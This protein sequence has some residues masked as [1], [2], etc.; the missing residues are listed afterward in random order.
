MIELTKW[1]GLQ[2]SSSTMICMSNWTEKKTIICEV[3]LKTRKRVLK[4]TFDNN[5][6]PTVLFQIDEDYLLVGTADGKLEMWNIEHEKIVLQHDAHENSQQGI[7]SIVELRDPSYCLRGERGDADPEIR[8]LVTSCFDRPEFKM[9][10]MNVHA[11]QGKPELSF[12]LQ[13]ATSLTGI[14]RI[15]QSTPSQLVCVD[16]AQTL[17]FYD[18]VDRVEQRKKESFEEKV[19]KF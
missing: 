1:K 6:S 17:K 12:H 8:Y 13:I 14:S 15:L 9:W 5:N 4:K 11:S 10:K 7:S 19:A 16:P 3:E 2:L 18:F